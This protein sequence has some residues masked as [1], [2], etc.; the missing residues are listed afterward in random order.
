MHIEN[1]IAE[2]PRVD[3]VFPAHFASLST[4]QPWIQNVIQP[5][6][7]L[8]KAPRMCMGRLFQQA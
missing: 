6:R 4:A 7:I 3:P 8:I 1:D 2:A 5:G